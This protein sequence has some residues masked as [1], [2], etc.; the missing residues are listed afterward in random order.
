MAL[1]KAQE[2]K[3]AEIKKELEKE[4]MKEIKDRDGVWRPTVISEYFK[5]EYLECIPDADNYHR[6]KYVFS[7]EG[8][9]KDSNGRPVGR[10]GHIALF[11][12]VTLDDLMAWIPVGAR[13]GVIYCGE[14]P[15][16]GYKR[17]TKLFDVM[18]DEELDIPIT[19]TARDEPKPAQNLNSFD[20]PIARDMIEDCKTFLDSEGI[21]NP[22]I[23]NIAEYAE[24]LINS[25]DTPNEQLLDSVHVILAQDV[26]AECAISLTT[27][28]NLSPSEEEVAECAEKVLK[29]NRGILTKVQL[30]LAENVKSRKLKEE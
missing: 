9:L 10:D 14:K 28:D 12:G 8:E 17:A 5:G 26:I 16:P 3:I 1:T 4:G 23:L 19:T 2:A 6:N 20:D 18:S 29:N 24:N 27:D 22:T 13:V 11:G 25:E 30:L 21:K 15:N 7:D